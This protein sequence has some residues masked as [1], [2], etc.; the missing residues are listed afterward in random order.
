MQSPRLHN[1]DV[2]SALRSGQIQAVEDLYTC[3]RADFFR[4]GSR[5]FDANRHDL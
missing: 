2:I 3:Y 1:D 4:W 5:R